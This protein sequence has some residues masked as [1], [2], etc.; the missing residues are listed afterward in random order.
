MIEVKV[1]FEP[2][3]MWIG[4]YWE[5]KM[6]FFGWLYFFYICIIPMFPICI[7]YRKRAT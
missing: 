7:R 1:K 4:L 5:R 6:A 3:D 2:R